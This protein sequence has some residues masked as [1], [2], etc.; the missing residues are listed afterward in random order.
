MNKIEELIKQLTI[1]EKAS[2]L[3]GRK[4]WHTNKISRLNIPSIYITDGPHGLRKKKEESNKEIGFGNT[5]ISTCFPAAVTSGATWN[6]DLLY[7]MGNAMG[8]ECNHYDV[9]IILG[10]AINIKRNPLC[11]RNFEYF[12]EDPLITG[13]LGSKLTQGIEIQKVGTSVKHFACNNNELNRYFGNSIVDNRAFRE[14]YLKAFERII[15]EANP[16][17]VMCA[18]N[19]VNDEFASENKT[20]L[21]DILRKEWG[22]TGLVMSDWGAVNDRVLGVK[23]G[24][25]L[26]MPGDVKYNRQQIVDAYKK[27]KLSIDEIDT[28]VRN[29]LN[30]VYKY[31]DHPINKA[32]F[33]EN[34]KLSRMIKIFVNHI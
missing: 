28:A 32:D 14:I 12:S 10:P 25:D 33:D 27:G 22:Y 23:A 24:L 17:T 19:M 29:I 13:I 31:F 6:K 1:E 15:K 9:N 7:Q 11:G 26:E 30:M 16:A 8:V 4:S 34:S 5:E 2:L 21:T 18:Y 3:S 20:L